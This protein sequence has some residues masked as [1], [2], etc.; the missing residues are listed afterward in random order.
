M[1]QR[2]YIA[3]PPD[4]KPGKSG[5]YPMDVAVADYLRWLDR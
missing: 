3:R 5:V 4:K 2:C 1:R